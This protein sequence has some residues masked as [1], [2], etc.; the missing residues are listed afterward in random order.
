MRRLVIVASMMVFGLWLVASNASATYCTS[1]TTGT[2]TAPTCTTTCCND[3]GAPDP[4]N[5]PMN[6]CGEIDDLVGGC[7]DPAGGTVGGCV[8]STDPL[9]GTC[10]DAA[11]AA[12]DACGC[13]T[14][15][16]VAGACP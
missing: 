7:I 15:T 5:P 8:T 16:T 9:G 2:L 14:A 1:A 13:A 3:P 10:P 6:L 4:M 12:C 11:V